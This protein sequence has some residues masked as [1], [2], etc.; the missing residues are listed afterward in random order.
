MEK[1]IKR[2]IATEFSLFVGFRTSSFKLILEKLLAPELLGILENK[3]DCYAG[4]NM[5]GVWGGS[6]HLIASYFPVSLASQK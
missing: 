5:V 2:Y 4:Y 1:F 3:L 6:D